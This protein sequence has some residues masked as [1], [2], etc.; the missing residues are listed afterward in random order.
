MNKDNIII[1]LDSYKRQKNTKYELKAEIS[2]YIRRF[3]GKYTLNL[4]T[5]DKTLSEDDIYLILKEILSDLAQEVH[6]IEYN[7]KECYEITF[8]LLYYEKNKEDFAY[9]CLPQNITK[10][11][12]AEYLLISTSIYELK[13]SGA[14]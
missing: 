14:L 13:K 11:K 6:Q 5:R 8:T 1:S 3:D 10:E 2:I 12:L 9:I 7:P 4:Y